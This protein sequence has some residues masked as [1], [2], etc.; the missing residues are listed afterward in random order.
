MAKFEIPQVVKAKTGSTYTVSNTSGD[1]GAFI[2]NRGGGALTV[3]LPAPA[4]VTP[5]VWVEFF[6]VAAGDFVLTTAAGE[7]LV[8]NNNATAD[9]YTLGTDNEEIGNYTKAICD[10]TSWLIVNGLSFETTT[11]TVTDA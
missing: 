11:T 7:A 9:S 10:G 4:T 5:G 2:T 6:Q 3:T 1:W 8:V